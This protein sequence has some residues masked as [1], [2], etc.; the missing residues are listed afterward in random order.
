MVCLLAS[1]LPQKGHASRDHPK[2]LASLMPTSMRIRRKLFTALLLLLAITALSATGYR[3]LGGPAVGFLQALYMAVI[4]LAGVGYNEVVDTS[5][6]PGLR[7][8]N[9]IVV[10][11]GVTISV[12][13]F[14][15][16]T[17]FFVEGELTNFFGRRRMEKRIRGLNNHYVVCGLGDTG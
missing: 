15:V 14:S 3:L 6:N 9:I 11:C 1:L 2:V 16:V 17:A 8:F 12:Y 7:V 4:T 5:R 10:F 13:V